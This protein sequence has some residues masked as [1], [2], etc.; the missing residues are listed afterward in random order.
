MKNQPANKAPFK[1]WSLVLSLL[2]LITGFSL[3]IFHHVDATDGLGASEETDYYSDLHPTPLYSFEDLAKGIDLLKDKPQ[4]Q[5]RAATPDVV[6]DPEVLFHRADIRFPYDYRLTGIGDTTW[7]ELALRFYDDAT[8]AELIAYNNPMLTEA[9]LYAGVHVTLPD[10]KHAPTFADLV[11][12]AKTEHFPT[13]N[14]SMLVARETTKPSSHPEPLKISGPEF[15]LF[16]RVLAKEQGAN[17]GY[18]GIRML[19]ETITNR[20]RNYGS[21]FFD[22]LM[23]PGQYSVVDSGA[24]LQGEPS[25]LVIQAAR[26]SLQGNIYLDSNVEYFCTEEAYDRVSWFH[27]L[28]KVLVHR[29]VVFMAR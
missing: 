26:D 3:L 28:H 17:W 9:D 14:E 5:V 25:E 1:A 19:A 23:Q 13:L 24:Y 16:C 21:S 10:P 12:K 27:T 15:E 20:V 22:I 4:V 2:L 29:G 6:V 7:K 8:K 18:K 11:E